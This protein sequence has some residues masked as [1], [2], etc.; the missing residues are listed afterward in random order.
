MLRGGRRWAFAAIAALVVLNV[1]LVVILLR[2]TPPPSERATPLPS[3]TPVEVTPGVVAAP[4]FSPEPADAAAQ[5]GEPAPSPTAVVPRPT[6][7]LLAVASDQV[8]WRAT[9]GSCEEPGAL[10]RTQDGGATWTP[11]PF[12]LTPFARLKATSPTSLFAIGGGAD[13]APTFAF[14]TNAG[15]AWTTEDPELDGA[16]YLRPADGA[17]VH[18]PGAEVPVPCVGPVVDLA[19]VDLGR[20]ALLCADGTVVTT[21][22]S[23]VTWAPVGTV[24]GAVAIAPAGAGYVL[25]SVQDT[26]SGVAVHRF[27]D[28]GAGLVTPVACA[29]VDAQA[30]QV[31]LGASGDVVWLWAA[32]LTLVSRDGGFTW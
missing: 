14:S 7:R 20:A 22:D 21:Q 18:G 1:V 5:Q 19:G 9:T 15:D 8:A 16:W 13:C 25:G 29:V 6:E 12:A 32:S 10:E 17:T 28:D 26:C 27:T 3:F 24:P 31:T 2:P 23:G 11:L 30:G 4:G